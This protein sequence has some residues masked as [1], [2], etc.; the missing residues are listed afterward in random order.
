MWFLNNNFASL[1]FLEDLVDFLVEE[2]T[3][4]NC[5]NTTYYRL[6]SRKSNGVHQPVTD[7][8]PEEVCPKYHVKG[9]L[10]ITKPN[11]TLLKLVN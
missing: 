8:R 10:L 4:K 7:R 1:K 11:P 5:V 2:M 3:L 6:A 9:L